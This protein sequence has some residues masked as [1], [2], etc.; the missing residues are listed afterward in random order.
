MKEMPGN[1]SVLAPSERKT[2][3]KNKSPLNYTTACESVMSAAFQSSHSFCY[4][5]LTCSSKDDERIKMT[6]EKSLGSKSSKYNIL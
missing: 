6:N 4:K 2:E 5:Q 3:K 1:P